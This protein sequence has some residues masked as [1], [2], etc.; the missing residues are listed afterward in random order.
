MESILQPISLALDMLKPRFDS[1]NSLPL[2][3]GGYSFYPT[4]FKYIHT[5]LKSNHVKQDEYEWLRLMAQIII[6]N[7]S[8]SLCK[9]S[10]F[11]TTHVVVSVRHPI[12]F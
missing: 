4:L 9:T 8:L 5:L 1:Y 7:D 11:A 6:F 12:T 3:M 10:G 2:K